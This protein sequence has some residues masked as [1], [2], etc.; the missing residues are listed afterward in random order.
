M[1]KNA[2]SSTSK[3]ETKVTR[4]SARDTAPTKKASRS[5]TAV[6]T[7]PAT[8]TKTRDQKKDGLAES[9]AVKQTKNP[10]RQ[11]LRYFKGAWFELRQVRWPDRRTTWAMTG[12]LL[13]FTTFF[14]GVIVL[15]DYGFNYL[16]KLIIGTN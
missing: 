16:F 10:I 9:D 15:I 12:A 1:A 3:A 13:L 14:I 7:K 4:I 6:K 8:A 2:K 11:L 5:K